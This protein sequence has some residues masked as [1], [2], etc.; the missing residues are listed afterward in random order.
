MSKVKLKKYGLKDIIYFTNKPKEREKRIQETVPSRS[1][2]TFKCNIKAAERHPD[3]QI[4][5]I[6]SVTDRGKGVKTYRLRKKNIS[7]C[8]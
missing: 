7:L 4:F 2:A 8:V 1:G 6:E 5:V 3:E